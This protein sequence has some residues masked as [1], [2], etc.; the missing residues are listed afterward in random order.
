M[1]FFPFLHFFKKGFEWWGR[2]NIWFFS[3][4]LTT[5]VSVKRIIDSWSSGVIRNYST[6]LLD[7][8]HCHLQC[9]VLLIRL[10]IWY[11]I[12]ACTLFIFFLTFLF[13]FSN[14]T[15]L[16]FSECKRRCSSF[17]YDCPS[18]KTESKVQLW[19]FLV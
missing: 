10:P 6:L 14:Q 3:G 15:T 2:R 4:I 11:W 1:T 18:S 9:C 12:S 13:S 8:G 16:L 17:R 19:F 5:Y 7:L